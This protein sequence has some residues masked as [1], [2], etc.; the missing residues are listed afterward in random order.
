MTF[1]RPT[2][3]HVQDAT[4]RDGTSELHWL[5]IWSAVNAENSMKMLGARPNSWYRED[6]PDS[7]QAAE[8]AVARTSSGNL[9]P[10]RNSDAERQ[11]AWPLTRLPDCEPFVPVLSKVHVWKVDLP[12]AYRQRASSPAHLGTA[13]LFKHHRHS[14]SRVE[15][16]SSYS[17]SATPEFRRGVGA[18]R[19]V[20][21]R[22]VRPSC[23]GPGTCAQPA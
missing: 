21:G 6:L 12:S 20:S 15:S 4:V 17:R 7:G 8:V 1:R 2:G 23:R 3:G 22:P 16:S 5:A 11:R 18:S 9:V 14:N 13:H 19:R 10:P